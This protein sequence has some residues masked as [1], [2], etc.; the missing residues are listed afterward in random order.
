MQLL[1]WAW[2]WVATCGSQ[3]SCL[4]EGQ[5]KAGFVGWEAG[6]QLGGQYILAWAERTPGSILWTHHRRSKSVAGG[7]LTGPVVKS[8]W[9][10]SDW[11][12]EKP[13]FLPQNLFCSQPGIILLQLCYNRSTMPFGISEMEW[14]SFTQAASCFRGVLYLQ[15]LAVDCYGR[16]L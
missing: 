15:G 3:N 9:S 4:V 6:G 8:R 14:W 10:C 1:A 7:D 2:E 5:P 16:H 13:T 11:N 12:T